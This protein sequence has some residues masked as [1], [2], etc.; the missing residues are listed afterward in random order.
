MDNLTPSSI[1]DC[2]DEDGSL[3]SYLY[4]LYRRQQRKKRQ[5]IDAVDEILAESFEPAEL[6]IEQKTAKRERKRNN[7]IQL[8]RNIDGTTIQISPRECTWYV[9]YVLFPKFENRKF[10]NKFRRRFRCSYNSYTN[11][12]EMVKADPKFQRWQMSDAAGKL[13]SPIELCLLGSLRYLARGWTFDDVEESTSVSEETHRQFFHCFISWG[14]SFLFEKMVCY[15]KTSIECKAST[16]EYDYAGFHGCIAST[17]ATHVTMMRC[18][19]TRANEHRGHKESMPAR[20]YN[21]SVNHRRKILHTTTGHPSR[22]NDKTLAHF[23]TFI[24]SIKDGNIMADHQ[25]SLLERNG[26]N[27][28]KRNYR[29]CWIMCD[30]GYQNWPCLMSPIKDP[31]E[32]MELRW[33]KWLESMRKDVECTFGILKGRFRILKTGVRFHKIESVDKLWC[34][35]CALHNLFLEDDG[36]SHNWENGA[37]SEWEEDLDIRDDD[38]DYLDVSDDEEEE[39]NQIG[40]GIVVQVD[41]TV[42]DTVLDEEH[43]LDNIAHITG[44]EIMVNSCSN[45]YLR[46]KLIGHFDILFERNMVK[47]PTRTG[48]AEFT[49]ERMDVL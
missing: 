13:P 16:K 20:T 18:P 48:L 38:D 11:L 12:L 22:W 15:P 46:D 1:K 27:I 28:N 44:D 39:N 14:S 5:S 4:F 42:D 19:V 8:V 9:T 17:D 37:R 41:D 33:S 29:G 49:F 35:C 36:L 24:K 34:T 21:I 31:I 26:T 3:N 6:Q 40:E 23:D 10:I 47:W 32:F 2:I 45:K 25:F 30:N 7:N 43:A